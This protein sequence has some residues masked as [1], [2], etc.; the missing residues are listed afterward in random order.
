MM[1]PQM[2]DFPADKLKENYEN[3]YQ[4]MKDGQEEI[5]CKQAKDDHT[6]MK[7]DCLWR[8]YET[9]K[10]KC[11]DEWLKK[12]AASE[13]SIAEAIA[14]IRAEQDE[15]AQ[16]LYDSQYANALDKITFS[17]NTVAEPRAVLENF[18]QAVMTGTQAQADSWYANAGELLQKKVNENPQ[19]WGSIVN[20]WNS[21]CER[22]KQTR[23]DP[24]IT[25]L[26]NQL[27]VMENARKQAEIVIAQYASPLA[28]IYEEKDR[29][30]DL[31][32]AR[33]EAHE[34]RAEKRRE[35]NREMYNGKS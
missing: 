25:E 30:A 11:G 32:K 24:R 15:K 17:F 4:L 8:Q 29:L 10:V 3:L 6:R 33:N 18:R 1:K 34:A 22:Y 31:A 23:L 19:V 28:K 12:I 13:M 9:H 26:Q 5:L 16:T 21:I 7:L 27:A 20:D 35:K 14:S 2:A